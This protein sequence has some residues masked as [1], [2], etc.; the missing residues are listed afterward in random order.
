MRRAAAAAFLAAFLAASCAPHAPSSP[1]P[2]AS[3]IEASLSVLRQGQPVCGAVA[4]SPTA[5]A[6]AAH[7]ITPTATAT[8][9]RDHS[10]SLLAAT[11]ISRNDL[12]DVAWL[13]VAAGHPP[14]F[15][16]L[17]ESI[18][19]FVL[20][21]RPY[22]NWLAT[23]ARAELREL[24]TPVAPGD[25]GSPVFDAA[26]G[27]VTGIITSCHVRSRTDSRCDPARGGL[28]TLLASGM[29]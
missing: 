5:I 26:T 25:S 11:L 18:S 4:V 1:Q 24:E 12:S 13:R 7:C 14:A 17:S 19:P 2:L 22:R 21:V 9:L 10:G 27:R 8:V 16:P 28:M 15:A 29:P 6:T 3:S 20:L 23:P